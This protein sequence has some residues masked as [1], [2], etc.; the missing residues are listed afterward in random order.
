MIL[1]EFRSKKFEVGNQRVKVSVEV[2][3]LS[4]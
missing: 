4:I 3:V 1:S 2:E